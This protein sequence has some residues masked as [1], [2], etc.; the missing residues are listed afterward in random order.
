MS[1]TNCKYSCDKELEDINQRLTMCFFL[2][3]NKDVKLLLI[4][5]N[6]VLSCFLKSAF[7][8]KDLSTEE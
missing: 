4:L 3:E 8:C 1:S 5:K 2:N 6:T 7:L